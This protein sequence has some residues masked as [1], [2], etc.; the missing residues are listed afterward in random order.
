MWVL[1]MK[2]A[3]ATQAQGLLM[4]LRRQGCGQD[5]LPLWFCGVSC[6]G[7]RAGSRHRERGRGQMGWKRPCK[8]LEPRFCTRRPWLEA[9]LLPEP[10]LSWFVSGSPRLSLTRCNDS[11]GCCLSAH[12]SS[13]PQRL[14][15]EVAGPRPTPAAG[16]RSW[17]PHPQGRPFPRSPRLLG[18]TPQLTV[19][20]AL[21]SSQAGEGGRELVHTWPPGGGNEAEGVDQDGQGPGVRR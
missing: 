1:G 16:A 10:S 12:S 13:S 20:R 2:P 18:R 7:T 15:R 8:T 19:S 11:R 9:A 3:G 17:S 5:D 4:L 6:D 14:A 21:S